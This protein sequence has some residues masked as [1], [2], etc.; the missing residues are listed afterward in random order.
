M[1]YVQTTFLAFV[2]DRLKYIR[3]HICLER[4]VDVYL[5]SDKVELRSL[6]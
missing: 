1:L 4:N 6:H 2:S 3:V 5:L